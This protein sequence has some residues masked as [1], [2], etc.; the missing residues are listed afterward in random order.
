MPRN[1]SP[2]P[3]IGTPEALAPCVL[4]HGDRKGITTPATARTSQALI[5]AGEIC[6]TGTYPAER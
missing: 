4:D 6:Y 5:A 3:T 1:P 2:R